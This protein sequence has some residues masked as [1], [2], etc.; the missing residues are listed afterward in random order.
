MLVLLLGR[1]KI[2]YKFH[3]FYI[4]WILHNWMDKNKLSATKTNCIYLNTEVIE[5]GVSPKLVRFGI[6]VRGQQLTD[7]LAVQVSPGR[8]VE[9]ETRF[10]VSTILS[11]FLSVPK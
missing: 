11:T 8:Q 5:V 9:G 3:G 7:K 1:G 4:T 2:K 10:R 6:Q